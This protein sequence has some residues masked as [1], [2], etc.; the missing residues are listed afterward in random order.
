MKFV[1]PSKK[2]MVLSAVSGFFIGLIGGIAQIY[3]Q[4]SQPK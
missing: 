4:Q 3:G 2:V 1:W